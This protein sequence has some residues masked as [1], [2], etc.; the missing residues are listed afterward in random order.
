MTVLFGPPNLH[1]KRRRGKPQALALFGP[2]CRCESLHRP[3]LNLSP[4][5]FLHPT[6]CYFPLLSTYLDY[7]LT[8]LPA[9]LGIL[10]YIHILVFCPSPLLLEPFSF[11]LCYDIAHIA[12]SFLPSFLPPLWPAWLAG[13]LFLLFR[14]ITTTTATSQ[15]TTRQPS[16]SKHLM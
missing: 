10:I 15:T 12:P 16:A 4:H 7:L 11:P 5:L 9:Y 2:S 3:C 6:D 8:Y 1:R 13:C 14:Y